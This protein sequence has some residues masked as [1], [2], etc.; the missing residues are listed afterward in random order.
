MA[1]QRQ[2]KPEQTRTGF[3]PAKQMDL[4]GRSC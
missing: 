3:P 2:P 4:L 1:D